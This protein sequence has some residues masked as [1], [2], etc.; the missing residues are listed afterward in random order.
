MHPN[1][2]SMSRRTS[3]GMSPPVTTSDGAT[4]PFGV[5]WLLAVVRKVG[6]GS[7]PQIAEA[8]V[9]RL[10]PLCLKLA[11]GGLQGALAS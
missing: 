8:H 5:R 1:Q 10:E 9:L 7:D 4:R 3:S 11:L 2:S 6:L